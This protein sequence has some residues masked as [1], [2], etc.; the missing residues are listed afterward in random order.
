MSLQE[1][2]ST[3]QGFHGRWTAVSMLP[4]ANGH[5]TRLY[6][7]WEGAQN[8]THL[9]PVAT[10]GPPQ[11]K[12][13]L[14]DVHVYDVLTGP[15][16]YRAKLVGTRI[17]SFI[18]S[19]YTGRLVSEY[20]DEFVRT[21]VTQLLTATEQAGRPLHVISDKTVPMPDGGLHDIESLWMP[22]G[23]DGVSVQRI[24]AISIIDP[25]RR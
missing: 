2:D 1:I 21:T 23:D 10:L 22:F 7:L 16:R 20:S 19:G 13:V 4:G 14:P 11:M 15:K 5:L 18:G 17:T 8:G 9:P 12:S 3:M 25:S 6:Q 24:V